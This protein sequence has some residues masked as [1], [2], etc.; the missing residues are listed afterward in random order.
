MRSKLRLNCSPV[1]IPIG[2]EHEHQGLVDLIDMKAYN[3]EGKSGEKLVEV[4]SMPS[5]HLPTAKNQMTG[6]R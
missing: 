5:V 1:Q 4:S 6:L 2:L 3:F